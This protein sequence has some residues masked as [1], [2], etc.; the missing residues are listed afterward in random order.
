MNGQNDGWPPAARLRAY[1]ATADNRVG[2]QR[3]VESA[4]RRRCVATLRPTD[5]RADPHQDRRCRRRRTGN[6]EGDGRRRRP[7][8]RKSPGTTRTHRRSPRCTACTA[9][10]A[11]LR[12]IAIVATPTCRIC[13]GW[14]RSTGSVSGMRNDHNAMTTPKT[15][16][17]HER[18]SPRHDLDQAGAE[19]RRNH[20]HADEHGHRECHLARHVGADESVADGRD[21]DHPQPGGAEPPGEPRPQHPVQARHHGRGDRAAD[22]QHARRTAEIHRR[23]KRSAS[24]PNGIGPTA[25]P[26]KNAVTKPAVAAESG[27]RPRSAR[28][29]PKAGRIR[30]IEIAA[31]AIDSP[32]NARNSWRDGCRRP[33]LTAASATC[34]SR[35]PPAPLPVIRRAVGARHRRTSEARCRARAPPMPLLVRP[36]SAHRHCPTSPTSAPSSS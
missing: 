14:R 7:P 27:A 20:R 30:S 3:P 1:I 5:H 22:E 17:D 23:P 4:D 29:R 6:H 15:R 32:A 19:R 8:A 9:T 31:D 11:R 28:M 10:P 12:T 24:R 18:A 13:S 2:H 33:L 21:R 26:R 36:G 25:I 34:R 35:P 16:A